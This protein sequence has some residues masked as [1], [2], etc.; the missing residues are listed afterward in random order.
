MALVTDRL[1]N[2]REG[3]LTVEVTYDDVTDRLERIV[4]TCTAPNGVYVAIHRGGNPTPW[5]ETTLADGEVFDES[6][7]FGGGFINR[8]QIDGIGLSVVF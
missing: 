8:D 5:R 2:L 1:V 7:P 3:Q 6:R 4:A